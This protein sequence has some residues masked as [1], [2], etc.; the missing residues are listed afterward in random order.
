MRVLI[1]GADGFAGH[2]LIQELASSGY[3]L[4]GTS[5]RPF[6]AAGVPVTYHTADLRD[7]QFVSDLLASLEPDQ[8]YHLAA[9]ASPA[10]SYSAV[11][12]TLE[13]NIRAQLNVI[14]GCL[15]NGL[16]PR[17]LVISSGDI[18]GDQTGQK[19]AT[20]DMPLRP[21]NPYSVSKVTQDMLALQ[22]FLSNDLPIMRARPFNHLG[23]R[24]SPGFVAPDFALQIAKIE[25]GQQQPTIRV[26]TL[27]AERDFTDVRDVVHAYHL[28]M[29]RGVPGDVYNIASG[30]TWTIREVLDMML[31][32]SDVEISVESD[33]MRLRPGGTSKV[34]G[35]ATHLREVTGWQPTIPLE[36]TVRDVLEDC[37]QRVRATLTE[38]PK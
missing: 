11:W 3:E 22:Y 21:S 10:R 27:S 15:K 18:Y 2:H 8:I 36:Q 5:F 6:E 14:L 35:D 20:E 28:I 34:W 1:T 16:K 31:S 29:E 24:Q 13:N 12:S 4:H 19:P 37:R 38:Q 30:K 23:P 9:Q 25:A 33:T 17:M 32:L 7:E 26:G